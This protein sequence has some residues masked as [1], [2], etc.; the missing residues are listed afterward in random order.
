MD[1]LMAAS[2]DSLL[3]DVSGSP[4]IGD[5]VESGRHFRVYENVTLEGE[6]I[7]EK[8]YH[9]QGVKRTPYRP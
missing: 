6:S 9:R 2:L 8:M 4:V 1:S 3:G 5:S 7:A